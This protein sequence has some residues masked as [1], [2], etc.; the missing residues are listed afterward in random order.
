MPTQT[1]ITAYGH[2]LPRYSELDPEEASRRTGLIFD[3]GKG[4]FTFDLLGQIIFAAWPEFEL[5]PADHAG[6]PK[7][8]YNFQTQI[9]FI[10]YLLEGTY[11]PPTG[12]FKA[13]HEL[14]WGELYNA[15]F[16]GR[17]IK[18]FAYGFGYK[19]DS[20]K[21]AA[22]ALGGK[23]HD[24]K[25]MAYDFTFIGGITCRL[26]LWTP[27]DEFPPSAQFLFSDN[28]QFAFNAEDLAVV[29]DIIITALKEC[30]E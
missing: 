3:S 22:A 26:I 9:L 28:T 12:G 6:C 5:I 4:R 8:L 27:D 21:H 15:N 24:Q 7:T 10:R 14:P 23:E 17:C 13:Y 20:F 19:P 1:Q 25:D 2:Y 18:R 30:K 11:I 29:G 16:R